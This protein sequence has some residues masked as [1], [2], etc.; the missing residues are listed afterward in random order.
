MSVAA[1]QRA[2]VEAAFSRIAPSLS[3]ASSP[4]TPGVGATPQ[5]RGGPP[6][7][8]HSEFQLRLSRQNQLV[9]EV[10]EA[11]TEGAAQAAARKLLDEFDKLTED[12]S[13]LIRILGFDDEEL[14]ERALDDLLELD[15]KGKVRSSPELVT[16]IRGVKS[17]RRS[18]RELVD[19]LLVKLRV[20]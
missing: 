18:V 19:V 9:S 20:R 11:P 13:V 8:H 6:Q 14:V 17:S 16:A 15:D 10:R 4:E 3:A 5:H 12:Q 1:K 2:E 7:F